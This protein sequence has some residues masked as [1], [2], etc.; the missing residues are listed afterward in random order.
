MQASAHP[1]PVGYSRIYVHL[2]G[3]FNFD[4]WM[5]GLK[6]GRSFVSTG[7]ML[8]V[9]VNDRDPGE[10]FDASTAEFPL[11]VQGEAISGEPIERIE[12]IWN[13]EV[14]RSVQPQ[15]APA[16]NAY[17]SRFDLTI[18][19]HAS[20]WLAARCVA[21]TLATGGIPFAHTGP[22]HV[23]VAGKPMLPKHREVEYFLQRV[24]EEIERN[25]TILTSDQMSDYYRARDFWRKKLKAIG[26]PA[27]PSN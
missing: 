23:E 21:R 27:A 5:A 11:H 12:I 18:P 16:D 9:T 17:V 1:V 26:E 15:N 10:I 22:W 7:P 8:L 25:R 13:G 14:I 3:G 4:A 24:E 6:A 19:A 2:P 20:G